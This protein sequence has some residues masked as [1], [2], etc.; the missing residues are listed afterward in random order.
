MLQDF[1]DSGQ[2]NFE[3]YLERYGTLTYHNKGTS[4]MPLLKQDRDLFTLVRKGPERCKKYDVVLYKN[5]K[6][7]YVLHRIVEVRPEDYVIL[8]DNTYTKE[9]YKDQ[10]ILAVMASRLL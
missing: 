7:Q 1:V 5:P 8:G 6:G 10:D 3:E 4:M 2:I 9:Y